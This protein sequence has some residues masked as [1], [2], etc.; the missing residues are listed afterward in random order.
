M[1]KTAITVGSV[2]A[3]GSKGRSLRHC[4]KCEE[5]IPKD[6]RVCNC[7]HVFWAKGA[8]PLPIPDY[9]DLYP[10]P[11]PTSASKAAKKLLPKKLPMRRDFQGK[12]PGIVIKQTRPR[13]H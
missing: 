1:Q 7:G 8:A 9:E 5:L 3:T 13:K 6:Q 4:D 12:D 10:K 11:T 2:R